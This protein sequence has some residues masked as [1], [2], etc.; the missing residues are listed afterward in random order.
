LSIPFREFVKAL[1]KCP[2][3]ELMRN[4]LYPIPVL[5]I[6]LGQYLGGGHRGTFLTS[7]AGSTS[8]IPH[9]TSS[10]SRSPKTCFFYLA[11]ILTYPV[12][13]LLLKIK[14]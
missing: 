13:R 11:P 1:E 2:L 8:I 12:S 4:V 7:Y 6:G 10:F 5:R 3:V 14:H 9:G